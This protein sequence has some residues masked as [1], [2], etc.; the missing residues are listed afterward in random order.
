MDPHRGLLVSDIA[1][2]KRLVAIYAGEPAGR[3]YEMWREELCRGFCRM[4]VEPTDRNRIDC[5]TVY[6]TISSVSLARPSGLSGRFMRTREVL[7][8]GHDDLLLFSAVRGPVEVTQGHQSIHLAQGQ[9]CLAEMNEF[10]AVALRDG[11]EF[12]TARIPRGSVLQLSPHAEEKLCQPLGHDP[13]LRTMLDQYTRLCMDVAPS[14]DAVGQQRAAQHLIDLT[15]LLLGAD[16]DHA[17]LVARRG[18]SVSRFDLIKAD[19]LRNLQRHDLTIELVARAHGLSPRQAQR[20]FAHTGTPFTE[21]VLA[22]R[23]SLA[24]RLLADPRFRHRKISDIAYSAG[25]S[26][27]SYFNREFRRRFGDTPTAIRGAP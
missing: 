14:L 26:D 15:S 7:S 25:F 24:H 1:Q 10:C 6:T 23:L 21:F 22:Q 9:M 12:T 27:L 20:F 11:N 16:A 13:A 4:D 18:Y 5:Q 2:P 3:S 17:E 8:D 19:V